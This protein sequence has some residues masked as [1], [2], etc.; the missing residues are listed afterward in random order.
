[1]L[2]ILPVVLFH[3]W[4]RDGEI[5]NADAPLPRP[6]TGPAALAE[7]RTDKLLA[8][9]RKSFLESCPGTTAADIEAA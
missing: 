8:S 5:P 7:A 2:L 1:M 6:S 9:R 4:N 3:V